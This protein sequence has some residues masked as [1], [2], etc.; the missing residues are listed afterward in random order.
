M[1][2]ALK[3]VAVLD[4]TGGSKQQM[5]RDWI[6]HELSR[7]NRFV[8]LEKSLLA[9]KARWALTALKKIQCIDGQLFLLTDVSDVNQA[10]KFLSSIPLHS[11]YR[12]FAVMNTKGMEALLSK[13]FHRI[14]TINKMIDLAKDSIL[15]FGDPLDDE[16]Q[17][18]S[19]EN[20]LQHIKS[21]P[22]IEMQGTQGNALGN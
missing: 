21:I 10:V 12:S 9:F 19:S 6:L 8:L 15:Y 20:N 14:Y 3:I 1:K 11:P 13:K 2:V 22:G 5:L 7:G 18:I 17:I 16:I 4:L